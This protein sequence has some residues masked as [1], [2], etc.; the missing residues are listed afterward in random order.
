MNHAYTRL[1]I[2]RILQVSRLGKSRRI[3]FKSRSAI[4]AKAY[5]VGINAASLVTVYE[6][7]DHRFLS[8]QYCLR[9]NIPAWS[10]SR[11]IPAA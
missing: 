1:K 2:Y 8:T 9:I 7:A 6:L 5:E 10:G 4:Q 3:R 11:A